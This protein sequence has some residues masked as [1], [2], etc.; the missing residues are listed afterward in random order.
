MHLDFLSLTAEKQKTE[1]EHISQ[2]P[3]R[4]ERFLD[5]FTEWARGNRNFELAGRAAEARRVALTLN[6]SRKMCLEY[7]MSLVQISES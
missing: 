5:E 3:D 4:F 6:I 7:L 1:I 2:D